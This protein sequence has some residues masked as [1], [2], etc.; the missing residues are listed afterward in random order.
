MWALAL[1]VSSACQSVLGDFTVEPAPPET[2][3]VL[4]GTECEPGEYRCTDEVLETCSDDRSGFVAVETCA[5]AAECNLNTRSCRRCTSESSCVGS[6]NLEQC[7]APGAWVVQDMCDTAALC[8]IEPNHRWAR[9]RT[10]RRLQHGPA[11]IA[12][13]VPR[14]SV[15]RRDWTPSKES[16]S[17]KTP[18]SATPPTRTS[19]LVTGA[20]GACKPPVCA[21][22]SWSCEGATLRRCAID[23]THWETVDPPCDSPDLC[24]AGNAGCGPCEPEQIECNGAELRRC[25]AG[26]GWETLE[27]CN[28]AALCDAEAGRCQP[29]EC[30][31]P[32]LLR[33]INN[34][35]VP[36][37]ERC[38]EDF[39]W[40]VAEVCV[41]LQLCSVSEGRCLAPACGVG[42]VRC[43]GNRL[44][45]CSGD[46]T[47][48][49]TDKTCAAGQVCM[50]K[51]GCVAGPCTEG[52]VRCNGSSLERCTSSR[53]EESAAL[54]DARA[55]RRAQ[56]AM[57]CSRSPL[58]A[59]QLPSCAPPLRSSS[60]LASPGATGSA[61]LSRATPGETCDPIP[62]I[63]T[64][65]PE[66]DVCTPNAYECDQDQDLL[67]CSSDG[68]ARVKVRTC[69]TCDASAT[70]PIC[71]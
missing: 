20:R 59:A 17:A 34:D 12:A 16:R 31:T 50:P 48:W 43:N 54:R 8:D 37:L 3:P 45:K 62:A 40:E 7:D 32:G 52:S 23:R 26:G 27:V 71:H 10:R 42:A 61:R 6:A 46:R 22:D 35:F 39:A 24:S 25:S 66:C 68:Q 5:S 65:S 63:G 2:P 4:L 21:P 13:A 19:S 67:R 60:R 15:A 47:R 49:V 29:A 28:A 14:S 1:V 44:E 30:A 57:Q 58:P 11:S 56:P 38:S 69:A 36:S 18:S 33:C 64:G 70:P 53:F 51:V 55:L 9:A 41:T